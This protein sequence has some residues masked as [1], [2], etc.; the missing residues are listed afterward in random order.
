[1]TCTDEID[2]AF[3]PKAVW[4]SLDKEV[5]RAQAAISHDAI[6]PLSDTIRKMIDDPSK[7]VVEKSIKDKLL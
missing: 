5:W 6:L 2:E 4:A 7:P 3:F 1:M